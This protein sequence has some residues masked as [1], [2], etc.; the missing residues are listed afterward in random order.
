MPSGKSSK[1]NRA[2]AREQARKVAE[3]QARRERTSKI[4]LRGGVVT[5]IIAVAVVIILIVATS[6]SDSQD[7]DE[8]KPPSTTPST[9][10]DGGIAFG[11]G[12]T[13][14]VPPG[15]KPKNA[16]DNLAPAK[17]K[18]KKDAAHLVVYLDLQCPV[19]KS[20]EQLNGAHVQNW[21][22]EGNVAVEYRPIAFLDD[23]SNGNRYSSRAANAMACV[24]DSQP[25]KFM[26]TLTTLFAK[27]P[28][29]D[30]HGMSDKQ[31]TANVKSAG[32][33]IDAKIHTK[34]KKGKQQTVGQCISHEF[35]KKSVSYDTK[36][37][38]NKVHATP[39]VLLDG[40]KV[41][42]KVWQN[43]KKFSYNVLKA[44]GVVGTGK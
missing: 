26:H 9:Y 37:A 24:A 42:G 21:A 20:F 32:V 34:G 13:P 18:T 5:L 14:I 40:K 28:K 31:L 11:K 25:K 16:P 12:Q 19:C 33:D 17:S 44:S 43:P 4:W 10:V 36:Q 15:T 3:Q 7:S 6:G 22:K 29:E 35:F 30:G 27:Q 1:K 8:A 2:S 38:L 39:T 41:D 23:M